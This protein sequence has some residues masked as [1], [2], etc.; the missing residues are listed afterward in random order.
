MTGWP[1]GHGSAT[2]CGAA[3]AAA[4]ERVEKLP[5]RLA[6]TCAGSREEGP[7]AGPPGNPG[8]G[9]AVVELVGRG[10]GRADL[11]RGFGADR[12]FVY[13]CLGGEATMINLCDW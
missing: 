3:S 10:N 13:D 12:S 11:S 6:A 5:P 8:G 7:R 4:W 2:G 1:H 9:R